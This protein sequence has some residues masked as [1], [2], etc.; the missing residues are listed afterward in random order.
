MGATCDA[1]GRKRERERVKRGRE[2]VE[3]GEAASGADC[4]DAEMIQDRQMFF[5]VVSFS[6]LYSC[7]FRI[8]DLI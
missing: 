8:S 3:A 4:D 2:E 1:S 5:I 6:S 7:K